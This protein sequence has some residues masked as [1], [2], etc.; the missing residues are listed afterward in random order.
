MV[1]RS[2]SRPGRTAIP[3]S[4]RCGNGKAGRVDVPADPTP[5]HA[6]RRA[7]VVHVP[8]RR[9]HEQPVD[10][11]AVAVGVEPATAQVH[12]HARSAVPA[13]AEAVGPRR[14]QRQSEGVPGPQRRGPAGCRQVLAALV[15][16][17]HPGH[18]EVG[19]EG[20]RRG[21]GLQRQRGLAAPASATNRRDIGRRHRVTV[22]GCVTVTAPGHSAR[23]AS[24]RSQPALAPLLPSGRSARFI[25]SNRSPTRRS[26]RSCHRVTPLASSHRTSRQPDARSASGR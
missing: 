21:P 17:R 19:E 24:N 23:S 1:V 11:Q 10:R 2:S 12:V 20:R 7:L 13:T 4:I 18:A 26:L 16:Q 9:A 22:T 14:E 6:A 5:G 25:A 15:T 3:S 8:S